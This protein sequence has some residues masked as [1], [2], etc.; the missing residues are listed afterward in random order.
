M[1]RWLNRLTLNQRLTISVMS[2][3]MI[4]FI[5][6]KLITHQV[7]LSIEQEHLLTRTQVLANGVSRNLDAAMLFDDSILA[8]EILSAFKADPLIARVKLEFTDH[9]VFSQYIN[10]EI[11]FIPP[12]LKD[13]EQLAQQGYAFGAEMLY[14]KVPVELKEQ[15]IGYMYI[16]V[17]LTALK[18]MQHN[19]F[20]LSLLLMLGLFILST[21]FIHQLLSWLIKPLSQYKEK[22]QKAADNIFDYSQDAIL[23][24][25]D[26]G[27]ITMVNPAFSQ[28]TGYSKEE[29][30][31]QHFHKL[32]DTDEYSQLEESIQQTLK[33][34]NHWQGEM[35]QKHKDGSSIPMLIRIN[36]IQ[37]NSNKKVQTVIVAS[38]LRSIKKMQQLEHLATHDTL[39]NLPNRSKLHIELKHHLAEQKNNPNTFAVLFV[40]LDDFKSINDKYGHETGDKALQITAERL[41]RT[42]RENDLIARLAGDE[43]IAIIN[44][45]KS[46]ADTEHTCQRI[47]SRIMDPINLG[48]EKIHLNASIGCYYAMAGD[49]QNADEVLQRADEAMYEAKLSGKGQMR[50]FN[51][52]R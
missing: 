52:F 33:K 44:P 28:I 23:V 17:S 35:Q 12:E 29:I 21:L 2:F 39:T 34:N 24:M 19:H 43:F 41:K 4:A 11:A 51:Q 37:D 48:K 7:Y 22:Q 36:T 40:D 5:T 32:A 46:Q 49:S 15:T 3:I 30:I 25:D 9:Q 38:D 8:K 13:T 18:Q 10:K 47:L 14:M 42:I 27:V 20:K 45:V 1:I 50:E 6:I 16:A 31:G 26:S